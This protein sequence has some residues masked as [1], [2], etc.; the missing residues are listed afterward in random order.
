M[1]ARVVERTRRYQVDRRADAAGRDARLAGFVYLDLRDRFGSEIGEV[2]RARIRCGRIVDARRGHLTSVEQH[3]VEVGAD[4]AHRH[5]RALAQ[6]GAIDRDAADPLQRFGEIRVGELADVFGDDAVD[7]TLRGA[8][9][10]HRLV[11]AVA[12]ADHFDRAQFIGSIR[13]LRGARRRSGRWRCVDV[14]HGFGGLRERRQRREQRRYQQFLARHQQLLLHRKYLPS[15][16]PSCR[17]PAQ[18]S[19]RRNRRA[20]YDTLFEAITFAYQ[21][22]ESFGVRF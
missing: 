8:L 21:F 14:R 18:A 11:E 4:A 9:D 22:A 3:Q 10:V 2:E 7:H 17:R 15:S 16:H 20:P 13:S 1:Q 19:A 6:R 12:D 5:F